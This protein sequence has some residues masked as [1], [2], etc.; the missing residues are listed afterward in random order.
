MASGSSFAQVKGC[1][2]AVHYPVRAVNGTSGCREASWHWLRLCGECQGAVYPRKGAG[3]SKCLGAPVH[4][5]QHAS[6]YTWAEMVDA[7]HRM[8]NELGLQLR[9]AACALWRPQGVPGT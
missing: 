6:D 4:H 2:S 5:A 1:A 3:W 8:K 7:S 9:N